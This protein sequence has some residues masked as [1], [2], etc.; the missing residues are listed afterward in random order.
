MLEPSSGFLCVPETSTAVCTLGTIYPDF[1]LS[2]A[3]AKFEVL[4]ESGIA[5]LS[6]R[7]RIVLHELSKH[8]GRGYDFLRIKSR[9]VHR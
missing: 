2:A 3:T 7:L 6:P 4:L 8:A 5:R 1:I 9:T